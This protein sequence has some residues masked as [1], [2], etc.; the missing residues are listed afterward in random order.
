MRR[1]VRRWSCGATPV[2]SGRSDDARSYAIRGTRTTSLLLAVRDTRPVAVR[3]LGR[4]N[5]NGRA[6]AA[7]TPRHFS[8]PRRRVSA[9]AHRCPRNRGHSRPGLVLRHVRRQERKRLLRACSG[10]K[11]ALSSRADVSL[12]FHARRGGARSQSED[13][14]P[15]GPDRFCVSRTETALLGVGHRPIDSRPRWQQPRTLQTR[16]GLTAELLPH[17]W[18]CQSRQTADGLAASTPAEQN[19]SGDSVVG[20]LEA[21][22]SGRDCRS[23]RRG[24][25]GLRTPQPPCRERSLR[26]VDVKWGLAPIPIVTCDRE[27]LLRVRGFGLRGWGVRRAPRYSYGIA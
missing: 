1:P 5:R 12:F 13:A 21:V 25:S 19:S 8:P 14:V 23:A 7:L 20:V 18:D 9:K 16:R 26:E 6:A 11:G 15:T 4:R 22:W 17:S 2:G 27:P 24:C 3:R 10:D